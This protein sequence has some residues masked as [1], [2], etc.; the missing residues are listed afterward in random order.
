LFGELIAENPSVLSRQVAFDFPRD[1]VHIRELLEGFDF[2]VQ[3][4]WEGEIAFRYQTPQEVLEHLLKSGAGT[5]FYEAV[6]AV[7]RPI[8]ERAFLERFAQ[9]HPGASSFS[10]THEY[11]SAIALVS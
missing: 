10:V 1:G 6:D 4:V 9:R 11:V 5:A 7:Q 3:R 8:L 2:E